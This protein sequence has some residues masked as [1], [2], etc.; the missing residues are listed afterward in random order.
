MADPALPFIVTLNS[1]QGPSCRFSRTGR[2][3]TQFAGEL[4]LNLMASGNA[5]GWTLKQ[6]Q[7]DGFGGGLA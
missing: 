5:G 3:G 6:V 4:R 1:V 7:R 2:V